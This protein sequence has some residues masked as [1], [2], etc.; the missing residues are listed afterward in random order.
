MSRSP[1]CW[2]LAAAVSLAGC[3]AGPRYRTPDPHVPAAYAAAP[4]G[5]P[6][7]APAVDLTTWWH[8]LGD[9]ELD[10]L[11]DR[12]LR[13]NPDVEIALDRLQAARTFE[14]AVL[15]GALPTVEASIGGGKGTGSDLS[16]ARVTPTL[17]AAD[18]TARIGTINSVGGFDAI[19]EL[20]L[21]GKFRREI[22]AAHY[23]TQAAAA[24]RSATLVA[25]I[26]DVARGYIELRGLQQRAAI[27]RATI[28]S[29]QESLRIVSIRYERGITNEL[30]VTLAQR[31]LSVLEAQLAPLESQLRAA[32]YALATLLGRY[33]EDLVA[34]LSSAGAVPAVPARVEPGLPLELL[35][36]RPDVVAAER[37][38][39]GA[40]ARIGVAAADLFPQ[41]GVTGAVGFEQ[42]GVGSV[43]KIGQHIWSAGPAAFWPLLDFGQLDARV[44]IADF[45]ARALLVTYKQTIQHAVQD[46]DSTLGAYAAQQDSLAKL[47]VALEASRRALTLANE[48]YERGLTDFLNVVDAEREEY[49]IEQQYSDAQVAAAN[50]FVAFYRALGGGWQPYQMLPPIRRPLPGV[51]A[52]FREVVS[53]EHPLRETSSAA[54]P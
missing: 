24:A 28:A 13:A 19:W 11:I 52:V 4:T 27:L 15:G 45:E 37:E 18:N 26:A 40:T 39:A 20:D 36:R 46:V 31:E 7:A 3:A 33:P 38:L 14:S 50:D 49:D 16:R 42:H 6:P 21:F 48:R 29:L 23:D 51:I 41:L 35:R 1:S 10:S 9:P 22:Q 8:A 47:A 34:E 5:A 32:Q 17:G 43:P 2:V 44:E 30:D 53:G 12:A 25:V 54:A